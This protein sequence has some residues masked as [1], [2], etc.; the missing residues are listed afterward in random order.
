MKRQ[1]RGLFFRKIALAAWGMLTMTLLFCII[2]LVNEMIQQG[3]DPLAVTESA[4]P[5]S[6]VAAPVESIVARPVQ[7]FFADPAAQFLSPEVRDFRPDPDT[8]ANCREILGHLIAGPRELNTPILPPSTEVYGVYL[9]G[10]GELV[11]DF[12]I[13]FLARQQRSAAAEAL[14]VHGIVHTLAQ[15]GI[16][17]PRQIPVR[18]VRFLVEGAAPSETL[19]GRGHLDF[20]EPVCPDSAWLAP[21]QPTPTNDDV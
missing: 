5:V 8:A 16:C 9:L 12:S 11:V 21:A 15:P 18:S 19:P 10:D 6:E 3:Y 20:A 2:L 7:L 17:A 1:D 13:D 4:A 14:M